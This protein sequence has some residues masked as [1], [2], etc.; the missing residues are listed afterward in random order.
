MIFDEKFP[1]GPALQTPLPMTS[2]TYLEWH[3]SKVANIGEHDSRLSRLQASDL[4]EFLQSWYGDT[5]R[6]RAAF[7]RVTRVLNATPYGRQASKPLFPLD[8]DGVMVPM[9]DFS[10]STK[11]LQK[12]TDFATKARQIWDQLSSFDLMMLT[13]NGPTSVSIGSKM[14]APPRED[15]CYAKAERCR[16]KLEG[17]CPST[18]SR[19]TKAKRLRWRGNN[20]QH[21]V[22]EEKSHG[23]L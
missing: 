13:L 7:P 1:F 19:Q 18:N 6:A 5:T 9:G 11:R 3:I 12:C 22:R 15:F 16:H 4:L 14:A 8:C 17:N 10:I 21:K 2:F 20:E 23:R